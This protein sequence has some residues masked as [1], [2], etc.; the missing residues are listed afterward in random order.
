MTKYNKPAGLFYPMSRSDA[1]AA[2]KGFVVS[3]PSI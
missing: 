3:S 1:Q 2:E